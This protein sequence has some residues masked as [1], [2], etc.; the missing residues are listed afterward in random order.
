MD[1]KDLCKMRCEQTKD[2][3]LKRIDEILDEDYF[4]HS[5]VQ[6][7]KD[8]WKAIWYAHQSCNTLKLHHLGAQ[9]PCTSSYRK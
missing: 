2:A 5:D 8:C 9:V 3:L 1:T 7:I 4:G 6:E